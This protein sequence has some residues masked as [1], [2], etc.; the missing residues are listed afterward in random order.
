MENLRMKH[1]LEMEQ[2]RTYLEQS[3]TK[4]FKK[5]SQV[6][7]LEQIMGKLIKQKK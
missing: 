5:S 3:K 6:L 1:A 7:N 4:A 2:A